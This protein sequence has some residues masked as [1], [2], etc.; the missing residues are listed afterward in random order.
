MLLYFIAL[1]FTHKAAF[2]IAKNMRLRAVSHL[3]KLPLGFFGGSGSGQ[4]N[5][6]IND[7]A[8]RTESYLAHQLPDL[9][10]AFATPVV[11]VVLLFIFDWRLGL[12]SLIPT[13]LAMSLT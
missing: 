8:T 6:V 4:L 3:M 2:R 5:R 12:I 7:S 11:V 1:L 9:V 10:S 13:V